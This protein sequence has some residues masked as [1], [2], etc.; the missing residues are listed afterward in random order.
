M[1]AHKGDGIMSSILT[2]ITQNGDL[3]KRNRI[4]CINA[5]IM[6]GIFT[7]LFLGAEYL[8]DNMISLIASEEKTVLAQNYALGAS[9]V[10]FLS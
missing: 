5:V 4:P 8:Y 9:A 10:G 1:T 7:F 6:M 2:R 3:R